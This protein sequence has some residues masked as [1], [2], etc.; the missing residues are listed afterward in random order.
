MS[1][2]HDRE[3]DRRMW[4]LNEWVEVAKQL[5]DE[6]WEDHRNTW[7]LSHL[8]SVGA[9]EYRLAFEKA[10]HRVELAL[11]FRCEYLARNRRERA[12]TSD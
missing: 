7:E 10:N 3:F 9:G 4:Y 12:C 6:A 2:A 1:S 11:A 8:P 5:R